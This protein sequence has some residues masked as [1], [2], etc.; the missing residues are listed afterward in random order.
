MSSDAKAPA[1]P[2]GSVDNAL[3]L[4]LLF[5]EQKTIRIADA[6]EQ[7]GVARSTAH[8]LM[9]MLAYHGFV[10]RETDSRAYGPGGAL[11]DIGLSVVKHLDVRSIARPHLE[12]L[13]HATGETV[14]L[15]RL[16]LPNVLFIDCVE[17]DRA[18]RVASRVG[19]AVPAHCTSV[20][21]AMLA[22][23][24][25]D[26]RKAY[27]KGRRLGALTSASITTLAG[28]N[29]QLADVPRRGYAVN[30]EESEEGLGSVGVAIL[31]PSGRP[32]GAISVAAPL[33]RRT[34]LDFERFADLAVATC[35]A[36]NEQLA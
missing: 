15:A 25:P 26:V 11:L 35:A 5:R 17:S 29:A 36:I 13:A 19:R 8:R 27:T 22:A 12:A 20:G 33:Q 16:E 3:R 24:S 6:S 2:I 32:V 23:S 1:Y 14:H 30:V 28:L 9:E 18:I 4:L 21:K 34:A 7:L 31:D 10:Q